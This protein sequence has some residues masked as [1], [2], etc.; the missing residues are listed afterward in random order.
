MLGKR[1]QEQGKIDQG[2]NVRDVL[3]SPVWPYERATRIVATE[4]RRRCADAVRR[5]NQAAAA[6]TL[7][8]AAADFRGKLKGKAFCA[9]TKLKILDAAVLNFKRSERGEC[10][11]IITWESRPQDEHDISIGLQVYREFHDGGYTPCRPGG[12]KYTSDMYAYM[13]QE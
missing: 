5:G 7:R 4:L 12:I 13:F 2:F 8:E 9:D 3:K 10:G 6:R 1:R 11:R